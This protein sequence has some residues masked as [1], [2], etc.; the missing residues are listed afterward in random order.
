MTDVCQITINR[1]AKRNA[2][3]PLTVTEMSRCFNDARDD[4]RIGV[5]IL[6]GTRPGRDLETPSYLLTVIRV[7]A[8]ETYT[9]TW[10]TWHP[11]Q[12]HVCP[13][14]CIRRPLEN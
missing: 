12:H 9:C 6:T 14:G 1:P 8:D 11:C 5:I 3:T 2:F 13:C 4:P 10:C 7:V